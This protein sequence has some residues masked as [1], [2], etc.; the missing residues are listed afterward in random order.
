MALW[1]GNGA[2][3]ARCLPNHTL[4]FAFRDI[5][6]NRL[7]KNIDRNKDFS[8]FLAGESRGN[9]KWPSHHMISGTFVSGGLGGATTLLLLYPFDF[10]RTR[11]ALDSKKDGTR[12]Y[13]GMVDCLQK[14]RAREGV[15]SWFKW[16]LHLPF[17]EFHFTIFRGL[18]SAMQFVIASRAIFFGI[19]DSIRTSVPDPETLNF[20]ACWAIAQVAI[21]TSGMMCYPLD[22]VRRS[23]MMQSGE[24][25]KQFSS[26]KDCWKTLYK[27]VDQ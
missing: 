3:V 9:A 23:M 11:L 22:T 10:A 12:K 24:K 4:N 14:I 27:W 15:S 7:L 16:V 1:R 21:V 25:V 6:R 2:G 18:S 26:T 13:K 5:Y 17:Q 8:K 20:A 19:F